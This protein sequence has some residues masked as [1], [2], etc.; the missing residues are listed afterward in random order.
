MSAASLAP[1]ERAAFATSSR[2]LSCLVTES[3]MNAIFV[4]GQ[5]N[6]VASTAIV[7]TP[8]AS[9]HE[10]PYAPEDVFVAIPLRHIPIFKP[11][12]ATLIGLLD[13]LDMFPYVYEPTAGNGIS[14]GIVNYALNA[15][16]KANSSGL[17]DSALEALQTVVP[18]VSA[19][20]SI[21]GP[22][23]LWRKFADSYGIDEELYD[24]VTEELRS[25]VVWQEYSYG[26]PPIEP[27]FVSP[28]IAWEQSI[29][30]GHPTHPMHKA[31]RALSP[32]PTINPGQYD[33]QHPKIRIVDVPRKKLSIQGDWDNLVSSVCA[34]AAKNAGRPIEVAPDHTLV[35]I[36]DL[37]VANVQE[38]FPEAKVLPEEYHV[39]A[40]AQQSLRS[41]IVPSALTS[42]QLK[43]AFGIRLTSAVRTISPP[44]AYLGPRFSS[45][46]VPRLTYDRSLLI[47]QRELASV[48]SIHPNP[49]V[50][51]HLAGIVREAYENI[52]EEKHG[53]RAIV[54]TA[55]VE[56]G[57]SGEDEIP[58]VQK[59]FNL[60][61]KEKRIAWLDK[62]V[63]I[64]FKAFLPSVITNGVAF[65]GHP[66][67]TLARF[68]L[69]TRELKGFVIRD[70]GGL[71]VHPPSVIASTDLETLDGIIA[72][73][74]SILADT[75][76][77]VHTRL[78][79]TLIHNHLQQLIRVLRLHYNGIG[80]EIVRR[81]LEAQIP[82]DHDLRKLWLNPETETLPGKCFMRMRLQGMYRTH[83]HGPFPNLIHYNGIQNA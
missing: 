14:N 48:S 17:E 46:I 52:C 35:P 53:E 49:D 83:L 3:L 60:D 42:T 65:E 71:R 19:L 18:Q 62:F 77:D 10:G 30:E 58:L 57:Y 15:H 79:H 39:D 47:V 81:H 23:Y 54:C 36:H 72:R 38:K 13:P 37:Q 50:A 2:L 27:K 69:E 44:S 59:A 55:L 75:T 68:D 4:R 16:A 1:A 74:H 64:F 28:S 40:L 82:Q 26:H 7:L 11:K 25:S 32:I 5:S 45:E 76:E 33:W 63:D 66:Q 80:W 43:L 31:R 6:E 34:V 61:T 51:K 78:Y 73:D 70:F 8:E 20:R 12:S 22:L 67:N 41:V 24:S 9:K 21:A 56:T 29:V